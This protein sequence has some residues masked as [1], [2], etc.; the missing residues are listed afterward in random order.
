MIKPTVFIQFFL[1]NFA[2]QCIIIIEKFMLIPEF[3]NQSKEKSASTRDPFPPSLEDFLHEKGNNPS[4]YIRDCFQ[5]Y[6]ENIRKEIIE[7]KDI[8]LLKK[9]VDNYR[10]FIFLDWQNL[11]IDLINAK[12][13]T[14]FFFFAIIKQKDILPS[15]LAK[16]L[17]F[18]EY[19]KFISDKERLKELFNDDPALRIKTAESIDGWID[20]EQHS[21]S[22]FY[23]VLSIECACKVRSLNSEETKNVIDVS[24]DVVLTRGLSFK[25]ALNNDEIIYLEI[26]NV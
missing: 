10:Q 16:C 19:Q 4:V 6:R 13:K 20:F 22:H 18:Q 21:E 8:S 11:V 9:F 15:N 17:A 1:T 5:K 24:S 7:N 3:D 2:L 14:V 25:P 26:E 23:Y 12:N